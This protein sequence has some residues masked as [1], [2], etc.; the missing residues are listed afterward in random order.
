MFPEINGKRGYGFPGQ[1]QARYCVDCGQCEEK[2][3]QHLNI[4]ESL[5]EVERL[6]G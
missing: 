2:C 6:F 3:P 1:W 4:R 5:K